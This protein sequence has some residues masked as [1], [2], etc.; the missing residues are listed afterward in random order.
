MVVSRNTF[1]AQLVDNLYSRAGLD[2][3]RGTFRVKGDTVDVFPAYADVYYRLHFWDDEIEKIESRNPENNN[4]IDTFE[5]LLV[6]PA[7]L[8]TISE[9]IQAKKSVKPVI[10]QTT[11]TRSV[12]NLKW[13][14]FLLM[15]LFV[16]LQTP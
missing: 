6:Y 5:H 7:N 16:T 2:F 1:L 10:Y 11:K 13:I 3:E 8:A 12:I 4:R 15:S 9:K 14:F